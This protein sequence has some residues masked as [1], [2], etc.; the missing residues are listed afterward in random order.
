MLFLR[1]LANRGGDQHRLGDGK[2]TASDVSREGRTALAK[3]DHALLRDAVTGSWPIGKT[4]WKSPPGNQ[5]A[6]VPADQGFARISE[7][8]IRARIGELDDAVFASD[9]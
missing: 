8:C 5:R 7:Q 3:A 4:I 1:R 6:D 2:K 9:D